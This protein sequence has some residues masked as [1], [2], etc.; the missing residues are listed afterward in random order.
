MSEAYGLVIPAASTRRAAADLAILVTMWTVAVRGIDEM[1][2]MGLGAVGGRQGLRR[3]L[4][5]Q[6]ERLNKVVR[7]K[8]RA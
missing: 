6:T 7:R 5:L 1:Y 8:K 2:G 3:A 4:R